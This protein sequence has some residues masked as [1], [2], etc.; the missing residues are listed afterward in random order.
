MIVDVQQ[1]LQAVTDLLNDATSGPVPKCVHSVIHFCRTT[2][3]L[4]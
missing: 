2:E 1:Q 3:W 4:V